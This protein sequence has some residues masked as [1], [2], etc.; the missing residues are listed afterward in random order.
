VWMAERLNDMFGMQHDSTL[1]N[2]SQAGLR[3]SIIAEDIGWAL[4][5][6]GAR[7]RIVVFAHDGHLMNTLVDFR[8]ANVASFKGFGG[9]KMAGRYLRARFGNDLVVIISASSHAAV[10]RYWVNGAGGDPTDSTSLAAALDRVGM[11]SFVVDMRP[12]DSKPGVAAS[13]ERTWLLRMQTFFQPIEPREAANAIVYF[14]H[15]TPSKDDLSGIDPQLM[16]FT[17]EP[18]SATGAR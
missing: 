16:Q 18:G 14:D 8:S 9:Y 3:D 10:R 13:L 11:P 1:F 4:G 12:A 15:I 6:E 7:G 17:I 2:A 5:Q